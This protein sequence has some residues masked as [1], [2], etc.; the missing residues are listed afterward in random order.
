[1]RFDDN[2]SF[3]FQAFYT[4]GSERIRETWRQASA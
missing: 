1:M 2:E 3:P 4:S